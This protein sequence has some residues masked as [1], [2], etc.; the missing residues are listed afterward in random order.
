MKTSL[1][2][3]LLLLLHFAAIAQPSGY[4]PGTQVCWNFNGRDHGYFKAA[5]NG[6]RHI[7]ISFTGDGET[8]CSNYQNQAPQKW[9]ND[10][11]LNWDGRTVRA[12][13]DTIIWEV[14]TIP[15]NSATFMANYAADINYFFANIAFIDTSDYSRFHMEG[16]SGGVGRMWGFMTNLQDHNSPY[17]HIFSTT[18]SQSCAWLGQTTEMA[19]YSHNRR[20]WVWYGTADANPGTPP[21]ASVSLYNTL[22]GTKHLTAQSGSGHGASTWD[23]CM[24]LHGTD[25]LTNRWLW[26]VAKNDTAVP[27]DIGG[28]PEGYVPGTQVN[29]RFNGRDHGYF[30]A[31]GCGERHILISF[32]G[33]SVID[34]TNYQSESPQ[35]LLNDL[36]INWDGRIVRGPGDTIIWEVFSI[37]YNSGYWLPNYASDINYFFSHIAEIDTTNRDLFHIV[38]VSG[39][40]GRMW[41]YITNDQSHNSPYRDLFST[42]ISVAT[43]WFSNYAPLATYSTGRRHWVWHGADDASGTNP[44]AASTALYNTLNGDKIL[45]FQAGAGHSAVTVDSVFSIAGTDSSSN[46]WIWMVQSGTSGGSL[47]SGGSE[48]SYKQTA[49]PLKQAR[50]YPNPATNY[51]YVELD[52]LS[53]GAYRI[54]VTDMSG[55]VQTVMNNVKGTNCQV[56]VSRLPKGMYILQAEGGGK[57]IRLKFLKE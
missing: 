38:G 36:G 41:G 3:P 7:L 55:R 17:R 28:G 47:L 27:C 30:R 42:T 52:A 35:K 33:D 16:L 20:H 9:L 56:D 40:V 22:N 10:A 39:G 11:G 13:G 43:H 23:S 18:I 24:S 31:A 54:A 21:A 5:G 45:T 51:V 50:L 6:E 15:H 8:N 32:I 25:T 12:P 44:P 1:L 29:W 4:T 19:A 2:F 48:L 53:R 49:A 26:M 34:S 46:R 57:N 37:P 14:L